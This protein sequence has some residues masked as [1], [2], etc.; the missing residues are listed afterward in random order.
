L[1]EATNEKYKE[2]I[3]KCPLLLMR[4]GKDWNAFHALTRDIYYND[5]GCILHTIR[6]GT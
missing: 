4:D 2:T 3:G 6:S 5:T 1:N